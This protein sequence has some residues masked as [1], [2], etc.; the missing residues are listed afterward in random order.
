[1]TAKRNKKALF[2]IANA[3]EHGTLAEEKDTGFNMSVVWESREGRAISIKDYSGHNCGTVACVAG[4]ASVMFGWSTTLGKNK[5]GEV[6]ENLG[7]SPTEAD[8]LFIP[9]G[10]HTQTNRFTPKRAAAVIRHFAC[11]DVIDWNLF[12]KEGKKI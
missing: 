9:S 2:Q 6:Q 7:L 1:M 3:I 4:T 5:W 11:E 10:H 8:E 12:D